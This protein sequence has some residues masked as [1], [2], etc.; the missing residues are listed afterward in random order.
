MPIDDR[1]KKNTQR[2]KR[3]REDERGTAKPKVTA[4][5]GGIK[6]Q[7]NITETHGLEGSEKVIELLKRAE[8]MIEQLNHLY[9]MFLSG[10]EKLPPNEKRK[11]LDQIMA[12]L[13]TMP[14]PTPAL[15]FRYQGIQ[16]QYQTYSDRWD[17]LLK[18]LEGGKIKR[19]I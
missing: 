11:Q 4:S 5:V 18:N 12:A 10:A 3:E 6:K 19:S 1:Y 9:N 2:R 16:S 8:P 17:R 14:K 15:K 13:I 7:S